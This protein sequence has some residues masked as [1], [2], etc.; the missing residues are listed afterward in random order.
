[1]RAF[2]VVA[3][4]GRGGVTRRIR[5]GGGTSHISTLESSKGGG[6]VWWLLEPPTSWR[7]ERGGAVRLEGEANLP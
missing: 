5:G 1:M 4:V 2:V 3:R 7:H 6:A